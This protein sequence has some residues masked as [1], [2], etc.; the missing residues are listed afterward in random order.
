MA[1]PRSVIL[2]HS[3][4]QAIWASKVLRKAGVDHRMVPVPRELSSDCGYCVEISGEDAARA[5]EILRSAGVEFDRIEARGVTPP[6]R[7]HT[8]IDEGPR[9]PQA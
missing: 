4:H 8:S 2:F 1:S 9:L 6:L 3:N 5:A 7:T